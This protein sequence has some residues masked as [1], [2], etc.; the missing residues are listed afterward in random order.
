MQLSPT[1]TI[2]LETVLVFYMFLLRLWFV[3]HLFI[4]CVNIHAG[5]AQVHVH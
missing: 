4:T 2:F 1:V 5:L 3:I